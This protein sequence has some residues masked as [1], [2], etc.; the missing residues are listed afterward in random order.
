MRAGQTA[1]EYVR[2]LNSGNYAD[3]VELFADSAVF[4]GQGVELHGKDAIARFY[5][6]AIT[7]LSPS[8]VEIANRI[9]SGNSCSVELEATYETDDGSYRN[10][11]NDIFSVD[12]EGRITRLAVYVR[13]KERAGE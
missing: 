13:Q 7:R 4:C 3:I 5:P 6:S 9:E 1:D 2:R 11:A 8:R 12:D 10:Y